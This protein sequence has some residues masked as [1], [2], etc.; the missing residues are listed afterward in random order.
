VDAAHFVHKPLLGY[1]WFFERL[2]IRAPSGRQRFNVLGALDSITKDTVVVT[3]D[4]YI[5]A[6]SLAELFN[7]LAARHPEPDMPVTLILDNAKYQKCEAVWELAEIL[8]IE[9]VY[10]P[11]YSPNLNLIERLW[12][13]V[14]KKCLNSKYYDKFAKFKESINECLGKLDS[15]YKEELASLLSLKFQTFSNSQIMAA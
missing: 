2:F 14:K 6:D 3:N 8:D 13:F 1:V 9:L 4:S 15:E 12:K 10:L 11:T 5:N 7:K